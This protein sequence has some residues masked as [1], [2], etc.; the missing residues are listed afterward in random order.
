MYSNVLSVW[1]FN[2]ILETVFSLFQLKGMKE[3]IKKVAISK[4]Q[5]NLVKSPTALVVVTDP[6]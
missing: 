5:N 4:M 3:A 2:C 6:R 1:L